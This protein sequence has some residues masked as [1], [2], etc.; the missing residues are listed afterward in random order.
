MVYNSGIPL[1]YVAGLGKYLSDSRQLYVGKVMDLSKF[2][3]KD[4]VLLSQ[5]GFFLSVHSPGCG[6]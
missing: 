2:L 6:D 4:L 5:S 1:A 3:Q